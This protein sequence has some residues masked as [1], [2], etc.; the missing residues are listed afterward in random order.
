MEM[1]GVEPALTRFVR[2]RGVPTA[3]FVRAMT[4]VY[5]WEYRGHVFHLQRFVEGT[6]YPQNGG[7]DWLIR[8]SAMVLG[9]LHHALVEFAPLPEA[10]ES[11]WFT[12]WDIE[13]NRATYLALRESAKKLPSGDIRNRIIADMDD[14]IRLLSDVAKYRINPAGFTRSNSH[15]DYHILQCICGESSIRAVIDFSS[16]SALPVAWEVIRSYSYADP[17]CADGQLDSRGLKAYIQHYRTYFPLTRYDLEMMPYLYHFQLVR[18]A[19]GYREYMT[20]R[21]MSGESLLRFALWRTELCRWLSQNAQ[22][23]SQ[24]LA[25]LIS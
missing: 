12:Q 7:P 22:R 24:E 19:Y 17:K 20:N 8:E 15:G 18:S 13:R 21:E 23:L 1:V 16:A 25:G 3:D 9:K 14:K 2:T 6:I 11:R 10:F 4:G 5:V